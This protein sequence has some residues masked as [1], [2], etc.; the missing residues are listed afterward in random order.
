MLSLAASVTLNACRTPELAQEFPH[1]RL[2]RFKRC[3]KYSSCNFAR[4]YVCVL[5]VRNSLLQ[6]TVKSSAG[7]VFKSVPEVGAITIA[8]AQASFLPLTLLPP[9]LPVTK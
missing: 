4:F 3:V 8:G 9:L 1:S 5:A 2:L 6:L 7:A